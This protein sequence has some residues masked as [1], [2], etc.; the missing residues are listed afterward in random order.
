MLI[1]QKTRLIGFT[2]LVGKRMDRDQDQ[3]LLN[4]PDITPE[5]K[6]FTSERK[7]KGAGV[8]IIESLMAQRMEQLNKAREEHGFTNL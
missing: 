2:K 5:K 7:L 1:L 3:L 4:W 6:V 8:S